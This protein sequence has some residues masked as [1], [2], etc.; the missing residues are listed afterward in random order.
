MFVNA[1][2]LSTAAVLVGGADYQVG[3]SLVVAGGTLLEANQPP[4]RLQVTALGAGGAVAAV[5]ATSF[6]GYLVAPPLTNTVTGGSGS[7]CQLTLTTTLYWP[8]VPWVTLEEWQ[9]SQVLTGA[10]IAKFNANVGPDQPD[11]PQPIDLSQDTRAGKILEMTV[12][13]VRGAILRGGRVPLSLTAGAIP[14][15]AV[16]HALNVAAWQLSNAEPSLAMAIITEKGA[17]SPFGTLA[18][19]GEQFIDA[20]GKGA[21]TEYPSD[22]DPS[23]QSMVRIGSIQPDADLTTA[24]ATNLDGTSSLGTL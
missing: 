24:P 2:R 4:A 7:G 15:E 17:Y 16:Q 3:D 8:S 23:F 12:A 22:P 21:N 6:G 5:S 14:P 18:K 20:L 1:Q 11:R 13:R 10:L 19:A 9:L